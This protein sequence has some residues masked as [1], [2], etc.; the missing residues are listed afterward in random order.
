LISKINKEQHYDK[1]KNVLL[2]EKQIK[3]KKYR[4]NVVNVFCTEYDIVLK[5]AKKVLEARLKFYEE[6][7]EGAVIKGEGGKK[8]S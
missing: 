7:H 2:I 5:T 4:K 3:K 8:L 6:D 1:N